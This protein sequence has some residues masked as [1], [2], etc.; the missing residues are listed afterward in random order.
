M[1]KQFTLSETDEA[2][3]DQI[4]SRF[5]LRGWMLETIKQLRDQNIS[6]AILS[7]QTDWLDL[8]NKK[9]SFFKYFDRVFNSFHLQQSKHDGG[10]IYDTVLAEMNIPADAALFVDDNENNIKKASAKGLYT[11]LFKDRESFESEIKSFL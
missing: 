6:T 2:L 3:R 8:L 5:I 7:D 4:F 11:I 9:N 1:R 10:E